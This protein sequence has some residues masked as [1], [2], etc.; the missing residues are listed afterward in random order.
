MPENADLP[1]DGGERTSTYTQA[2]CV[3]RGGHCYDGRTTCKHCGHHARAEPAAAAQP[4]PHYQ[5]W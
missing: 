3:A 4:P 2:A 5:D 1:A